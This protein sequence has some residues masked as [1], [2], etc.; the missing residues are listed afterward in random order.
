[1][2]HGCAYAAH[3]TLSV[4]LKCLWNYGFQGCTAECI[5]S[6]EPVSLLAWQSMQ[7]DSL[8]GGEGGGSK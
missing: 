3:I 7:P 2:G 5:K 4:F 6:V 8:D 1:M